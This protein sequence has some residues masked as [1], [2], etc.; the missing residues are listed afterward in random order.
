MKKVFLTGGTGFVGG[1]LAAAL[2]RRGDK[3]SFLARSNRNTAAKK[4][5]AEMLN[6]AAPH[7]VFREDSYEVFEGDITQ[8][9]FGLSDVALAN[10]VN[11][12]IDDF[13]HVGGSIFYSEKIA[14]ETDRTNIGGTINALALS[15]LIKPKRFHF[16]SA[17]FVCG[18]KKGIFLEDELECGQVFHN[19]YEK[20]KFIAEGKVREWAKINPQTKVFVY[21]PSIVVGDSKNGAVYGFSGYYNYMRAY[22]FLRRWLE[23]RKNASL[24]RDSQGKIILPIEVPGAADSPLNVVTIDYVVETIIKLTE[25]GVAGTYNIT[26]ENPVTYGFWLEEST[27]LLGFSGIRIK[28]SGINNSGAKNN[29]CDSIEKKIAAGIKDYLPFVTYEPN[30]S[31]ANVKRVLG[32]N[33]REP[34]ITSGLIKVLL[35]FAVAHEFAE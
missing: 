23:R 16:T 2:L 24:E 10:L 9:N 22:Y 26:A 6:F 19:H 1:F 25:K 28:D 30:F 11:S 5:V 31:R 32:E 17:A 34:P 15:E 3:V 7:F 29:F 12:G 35:D 18:D 33:Y 8:P 21:R 13:F 14:P 27:K 20:T 4:R